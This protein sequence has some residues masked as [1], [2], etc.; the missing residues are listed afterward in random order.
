[1]ADATVGRSRSSMLVCIGSRVA[2]DI[3][4]PYLDSPSTVDLW[5]RSTPAS[6]SACSEGIVDAADPPVQM[7]GSEADTVEVNGAAA[8]ANDIAGCCVS[9]Q[10]DL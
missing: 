8:A 9:G 4:F 5:L 6:S 2:T 7:R 1:M 3:C 10:R